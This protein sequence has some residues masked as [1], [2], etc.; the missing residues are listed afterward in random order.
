MSSSSA[1]LSTS[2]AVESSGRRN[3]KRACLVVSFGTIRQIAGGPTVW[4]ES[5]TQA[6][7]EKRKL[8]EQIQRYLLAKNYLHLSPTYRSRRFIT[9]IYESFLDIRFKPLHPFGLSKV[10]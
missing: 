6:L 10:S 1:M 2:L 9:S 5:E 4:D 3:I 7:L 8:M